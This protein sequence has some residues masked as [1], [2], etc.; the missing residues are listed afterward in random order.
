MIFLY[1]DNVLDSNMVDFDYEEELKTAI[2]LKLDVAIISFEAIEEGDLNKA[3]KNVKPH[4]KKEKAV[5]RGWMM[6]PTVYE[7]MYNYLL[8]KN[9][10]LINSPDEYKHCH[11]LPFSYDKIENFTAKSV[12]SAVGE[13]LD[14]TRILALS[15]QFGDSPIIVK[16]YVKSEKHNWNEACFIAKASDDK[17]VL[18][19]V[20]R[21]I[22]LR[23][24]A[25]NEG[26]VLRKYEV[27]VFLTNHTKSGMPLTKEYRLFFLF[28]KLMA[29]YNYWDEGDYNTDIPDLKTFESIA[30]QIQSNFFT[31][32]IAQKTDNSWI[33]IELGD[34][35]VSGLPE[36]ANLK[37][38][39]S[40]FKTQHE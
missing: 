9:I 4:H 24:D 19:V 13:T 31:M 34:A 5:Y 26:L 7:V 33:I 16:D 3:F 15:R 40:N 37:D 11:Y 38:F 18:A 6:K 29:T 17:N 36:N 23:G 35:Q 22:E 20:N 32:D 1:C 25:L 12:W 30:A 27:L 28:G 14:Q 10:A 8:S 2:S 39:Y 21:F